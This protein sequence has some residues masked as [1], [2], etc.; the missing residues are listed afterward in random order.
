MSVLLFVWELP[1][2]LLGLIIRL[3][4]GG[5]LMRRVGRVRIVSWRFSSGVSLGWY[6]F[7]PLNAPLAMINHEYGHTRQS[8]MLGPL[9]LVII[10]LPSLIWAFLFH[11]GLF[12]KHGYFS[13]YT[14]RWAERLGSDCIK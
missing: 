14:E 8:F 11:L 1:Q 12:R 7:V 4:F 2:I 10:G 3:L 13:F 9:Y 5:R 6:C